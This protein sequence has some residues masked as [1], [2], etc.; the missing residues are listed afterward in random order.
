[1]S[2]RVLP[3]VIAAAIALSLASPALAADGPQPGLWK[4]TV[5]TETGGVAA[6]ARASERCLKPEQL[7]DIEKTFTPEQGAACTRLA[8]AWTGRRLSWRIA[9]TAPVEMDNSGWYEFDSGRHYTGELVVQMVVPG[10]P[11]M[12]SRTRIEG[13]RI[14]ACPN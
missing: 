10:G 11:A 14:G 3:G 12:L 4:V 2:G 8:Y 5:T 13:E 1:M 9:C 7:K 6:P